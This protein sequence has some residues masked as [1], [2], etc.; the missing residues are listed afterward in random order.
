MPYERV[1]YRRAELYEKVWERPV[2]EVAK[3]Y[4]VSNVGL[5]KVC[6]RLGVPLPGRGYWARRAAGQRLPRPRLAPLRKGQEEQ[7][8]SSRW[9]PDG[10]EHD[11]R[12]EIEELVD[13]ERA[14]EARIIV[15]EQ[16]TAP[17][18][19]VVHAQKVIVK[20]TKKKT[21]GIVEIGHTRCLAIRVTPSLLERALRIMDAVIK[22]FEARGLSVEVT[23]PTGTDGSRS[24][25]RSVTRTS[26]FE[27]SIEFLLSEGLDNVAP[28]PEP[29]KLGTTHEEIMA[30]L[31]RP[32]YVPEYRPNGKLTLAVTNAEHLGLHHSWSDGKVSLEERLNTF[33]RGVFR[34]ADAKRQRRLAAERHAQ[35]QER[36][37]RLAQIEEEDRRL[38]KDR[39]DDLEKRVATWQEAKEL[40]GYLDAFRVRTT[41]GSVCAD[42]NLRGW[43]KW[44]ERRLRRLERVAFRPTAFLGCVQAPAEQT[45]QVE[46]GWSDWFVDE[47]TKRR[48]ATPLRPA[49]DLS[50]VASK[51]RPTS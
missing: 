10:I 4:G 24:G 29:R 48:R 43:F 39:R 25:S 37:R 18:E 21:S 16:F 8:I 1:V 15:P 47:E 49:L 12:P 20:A 23:E 50:C 31:S 45:T 14:D 34:I 17:H 35:E 22:A 5:A 6:K 26:V 32:R 44:A 40:D 3:D 46:G 7:I 13:H 42:A 19:L 38:E 28:R 11:V 2:T 30:Y 33:M 9:R 36:Q 41:E 27:E 51:A